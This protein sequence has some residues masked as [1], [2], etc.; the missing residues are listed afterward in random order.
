M[1]LGFGVY[2]A[3][4]G[5]GVIGFYVLGLIVSISIL[6]CFVFIIRLTLSFE[7]LMCW[8]FVCYRSCGV[9]S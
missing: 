3:V 6:Y 1:G 7:F 9:I 4:C 5:C 2:C 8:V